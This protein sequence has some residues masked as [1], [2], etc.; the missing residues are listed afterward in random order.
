MRKLLGEVAEK[1]GVAGPLG[2]R[3]GGDGEL[4]GS[5]VRRGITHMQI[6]HSQGTKNL[7]LVAGASPPVSCLLT[8]ICPF[9]GRRAPL[10]LLALISLLTSTLPH[11]VLLWR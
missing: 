8:V 9:P 11:E 5:S 1:E 7:P 2:T 4:M 3:E 10:C 6:E